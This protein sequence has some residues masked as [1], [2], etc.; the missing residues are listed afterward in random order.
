M[1]LRKSIMSVGL[2][3]SLLIGGAALFD[4]PVSAASNRQKAK[5][6][7]RSK[8]S[9]KQSNHQS[10]KNSTKQKGGTASANGGSGG[11]VQCFF[12]PAD[13]NEDKDGKDLRLIWSPP[14]SSDT[15]T[16]DGGKGGHAFVGGNDNTTIQINA[17]VNDA[18]GSQNG[19]DTAV[20][21][22]ASH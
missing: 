21:N 2:V 13:D 22:N 7:T 4:S 15:C 12:P 18:S 16:A 3:A 1:Q 8:R 11:L 19:G 14:A 10:N 9:I 20:A 5:A 17:G 6:S